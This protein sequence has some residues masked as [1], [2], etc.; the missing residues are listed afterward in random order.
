VLKLLKEGADIN[1]KDDDGV[2]VTM[3]LTRGMYHQLSFLLAVL[4]GRLILFHL[5]FKIAL[6][7]LV[8]L[9]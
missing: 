3:L 9:N 2:S 5:L 4:P 8:T 6:Q 7:L 1:S